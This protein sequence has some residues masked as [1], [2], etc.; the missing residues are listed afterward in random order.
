MKSTH[1]KTPESLK[2]VSCQDTFKNQDALTH[3]ANTVDCPIRC[4]DCRVEFVTKTMRTAHQEER[5]SGVGNLSHFME[6]DDSTWKKMNENL[7]KFTSSPKPGEPN[8]DPNSKIAQWIKNNTPR[9]MTGRL[10][11]AKKAYIELGQWYTIFATLALP[12]S[13]PPEHPCK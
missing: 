13:A 4:P 12:E 1:R 7:K 10:D 2:C 3:H 6:I 8:H 11:N 9:Y 5:H